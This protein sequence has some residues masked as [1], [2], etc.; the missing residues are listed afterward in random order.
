MK[1]KKFLVSMLSVFALT[2]L[3]PIASA[4]IS[5]EVSTQKQ[6]LIPLFENQPYSGSYVI[7]PRFTL[8]EWESVRVVVHNQ[9]APAGY[10]ARV[11]YKLRR[12]TD[13]GWERIYTFEAKGNNLVNYQSEDFG[14][15]GECHF[16]IQFN[17]L[18]AQGN[19]V[20][21]LEPTGSYSIYKIP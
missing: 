3:A 13:D 16:L 7:T 17:V 14:R 5:S 9:T 10:T 15:E 19:I 4:Q 11:L 6:K 21:D 20:D 2:S 18:D 8:G 1:A 12:K